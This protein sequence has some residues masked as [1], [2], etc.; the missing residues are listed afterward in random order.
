MAGPV[1]KSV[2]LRNRS[3]VSLGA[4]LLTAALKRLRKNSPDQPDSSEE[5]LIPRK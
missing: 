3:C 4:L 5:T 2:W 1:T